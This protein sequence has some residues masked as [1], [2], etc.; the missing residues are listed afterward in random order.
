MNQLGDQGHRRSIHRSPRVISATTAIV[1]TAKNRV[2]GEKPLQDPKKTVAA[3][4]VKNLPA[5]VLGVRLVSNRSINGSRTSR[6]ILGIPN[7]GR[8]CPPYTGAIEN[9]CPSSTDDLGTR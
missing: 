1:K 9:L 7:S 2:G 4:K 8:R 6:F 5:M 3:L